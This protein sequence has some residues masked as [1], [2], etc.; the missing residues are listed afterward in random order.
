LNVDNLVVLKNDESAELDMRLRASPLELFMNN[1]GALMEISKEA[2][3]WEF[4]NLL[5]SLDYWLDSTMKV[6]D[7]PFEAR[8]THLCQCTCTS[9]SACKTKRCKCKVEDGSCSPECGCELRKCFNHGVLLQVDRT[10]LERPGGNLI[11][12]PHKKA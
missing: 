9:Y 10:A 3:R 8:T 11:P 5:L 6:E 1:E 4:R 12:L 7:C 2:Y